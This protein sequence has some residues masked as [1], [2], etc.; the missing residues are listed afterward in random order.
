[1]YIKNKLLYKNLTLYNILVENKKGVLMII[2][3]VEL[4]EKVQSRPP[5]LPLLPHT[6]NWNMWYYLKYVTEKEKEYVTGIEQVTVII[7]I[8]KDQ[9]EQ[10]INNSSNGLYQT[11]LIQKALQ[12][13]FHNIFLK[14]IYLWKEI[15]FF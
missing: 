1:M 10:L 15:L 5:L 13:T 9:S 3:G 2:N 12:K 11:N 4:L 6:F 7:V 8:A 14:L